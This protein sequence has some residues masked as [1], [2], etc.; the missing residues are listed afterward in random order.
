MR[1]NLLILTIFLIGVADLFG[2]SESLYKKLRHQVYETVSYED[3]SYFIGHAIRET[4]S[5]VQFVLSGTKD[6][7][8]LDKRFIIKWVNSDDYFTYKGGRYHKKTGTFN[9]LEYGI[10]GNGNDGTSQLEFVTG[11]YLNPRLGVGLGIGFNASSV[12]NITWTTLTFGELFLYSKYYLND[13]RRR[14]FVDGKLGIAIPLENDP[15]WMEYTPGPLLQPGIGF[16]F[17]RSKKIRWS[18]KLSQFLQYSRITPNE[19]NNDFFGR[20]ITI[21]DKRIFNRT[22]LAV[23]LHF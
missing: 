3:G 7:I 22:V 15:G 20:T 18:I 12:N 14:L 8:T 9:F 1:S 23:G 6:T 10:G 11:K 21:T 5:Q 2:Q 17:A 13:N 4:N 19:I 16:E